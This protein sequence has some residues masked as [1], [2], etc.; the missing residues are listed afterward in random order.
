MP[1]TLIIFIGSSN[2]GTYLNT[3]SHLSDK[4][5]IEK[6]IFISLIE[7]PLEINID[8]DKTISL[9]LCKDFSQL[10]NG[11][12]TKKTSGSSDEEITVNLSDEDKKIYLK[13]NEIISRKKIIHTVNYNFF[14]SEIKKII[15]EEAKSEDIIFDITAL[16]KRIGI[17]V[18]VKL[19]SSGFNNVINFE[20]KNTKKANNTENGFLYHSLVR[21]NNYELVFLSKEEQFYKSVKYYILE[22]EK[23]RFLCIFISLLMSTSIAIIQVFI[24][25]RIE[26]TT[27]LLFLSILSG[28]IPLIEFALISAN[29]GKRNM[30]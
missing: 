21:E 16:P 9:D 17:D 1:R 2:V 14:N 27:L 29:I 19:L 7:A 25:K 23:S 24:N 5:N 6:I 4:Y 28:V 3:I 10:S 12:Y 11:K 26:L 15:K 20:I 22:Q 13:A 8:I 30:S 18:F